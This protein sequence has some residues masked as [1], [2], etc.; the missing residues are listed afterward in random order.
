M[1]IRY[2]AVSVCNRSESGRSGW[3]HLQSLSSRLN[4]SREQ[5]SHPRQERT[6]ALADGEVR[7]PGCPASQ[8]CQ[9]QGAPMSVRGDGIE[10]GQQP[11]PHAG[12]LSE[13]AVRLPV[14]PARLCFWLP[15]GR[16][17]ALPWGAAE[18]KARASDLS[19]QNLTGRHRFSFESKQ[20]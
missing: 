2:A 5:K 18:L 6:G 11:P 19:S 1:P 15:R 9:K 16:G 13:G 10:L 17:L 8:T 20:C 4:A 7:D 12:I 3:E 14:M